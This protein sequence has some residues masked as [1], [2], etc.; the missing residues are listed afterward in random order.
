MLRV[1]LI[2]DEF[3]SIALESGAQ[4]IHLSPG[5]WR[6]QLIGRKKPD[7][8]FVESAWRGVDNNWKGKIAQPVGTSPGELNRENKPLVSIVNWF[9]KKQIPTV[10]WNKEDPVCFNRFANIASLF[11][12]IY[13]T[14]KNSEHRYRASH[15]NASHIGTLL[16]AAQPDLFYPDKT[17]KR[18]RSIAFAGGYYGV[19]YPER[20]RQQ[21]EILT[22]LKDIPLIIYDR[23]WQQ[24]NQCSF[25]AELQKYC[26]PAVTPAEMH[27]IY[28]RH[29]VYLNFN[30]VVDSTSMLSR[31]VFELAACASP[32]ISTP[33]SALTALFGDAVPQVTTAEEA[34]DWC[35]RLLDDHDLRHKMSYQLYD[36]VMEKH[37]WHHRLQQIREEI[38]LS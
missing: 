11:D 30:T 27:S 32:M 7:L 23:F 12:V 13:T 6:W 5:N 37:T 25:P 24:N 2:A 26:K 31:R 19:E 17:I 38:N 35:Q 16:F 15:F 34:R 3:T 29:Q 20:S 9:R 21:Y 8:L 14:D 1:A 10:F 36:L 28:H 22:H 33:S 4:L 18:S